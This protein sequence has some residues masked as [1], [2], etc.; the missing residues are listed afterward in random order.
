MDIASQRVVYHH[1]AKNDITEDSFTFTVTNGLSQAKDG[2]FQITIQP[3]DK[4]LPTLVSNTLL[5]VL[6]VVLFYD[7]CFINSVHNVLLIV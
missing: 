7:C 5:E 2:E 1:L 6:Q 4:V 3:M